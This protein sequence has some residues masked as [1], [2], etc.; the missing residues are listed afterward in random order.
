M[1]ILILIIYYIKKNR[2]KSSFLLIIITYICY[3]LRGYIDYR[4]FIFFKN[5]YVNTIGILCVGYCGY[6]M[7]R[8]A[9]STKKNDFF[10]IYYLLYRL[11]TNINIIIFVLL[12][13]SSFF[14]KYFIDYPFRKESIA[15]YSFMFPGLIVSSCHYYE[16]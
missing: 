14:L 10:N 3:I 11:A 9:I 5:N 2:L 4:S 6:F 7:F 1:N 12:L 13:L 8:F 16:Q 15:L